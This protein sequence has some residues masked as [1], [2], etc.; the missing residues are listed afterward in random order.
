MDWWWLMYILLFWRCMRISFMDMKCLKIDLPIQF[1]HLCTRKSKVY[2]SLSICTDTI[3]WNFVSWHSSQ[4]KTFVSELLSHIFIYTYISSTHVHSIYIYTWKHESFC[5]FLSIFVSALLPE[6]P[7]VRN[8]K[9]SADRGPK[10]S[11]AKPWSC[12]VSCGAMRYPSACLSA[13]LGQGEPNENPPKRRN[14]RGWREA[15]TIN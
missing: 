14:A 2:V 3:H 9:L 10:P 13:R 5:N 12:V 6:K 15:Y 8:P 7:T 1:R 11:P 4:K